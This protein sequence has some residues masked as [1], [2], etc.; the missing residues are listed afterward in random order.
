ME[1][2]RGNYFNEF[3]GTSNVCIAQTCGSPAHYRIKTSDKEIRQVPKS[4]VKLFNK[5]KFNPKLE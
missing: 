5:L 2:H 1:T 3:T 4:T